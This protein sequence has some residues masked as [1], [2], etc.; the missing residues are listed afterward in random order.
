[1]GAT[2]RL[3]AMACLML[4]AAATRAVSQPAYNSANAV[5]PGCRAFADTANN[6]Q[7]YFEQG[8]RAG[9]VSGILDTAAR[10]HGI[11]VP[12]QVIQGQAVRVVVQFID[13]QPA[14]MHERFSLLALEAL[15]ATWPCKK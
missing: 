1:M 15:T 14:R 11:C 10:F 4:A 3:L 5:M 13:A 12:P 2:A 7:L 6:N 8:I 9:L